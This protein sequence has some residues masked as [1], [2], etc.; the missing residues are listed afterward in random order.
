[1]PGSVSFP[2]RTSYMDRLT[3]RQK[4]HSGWRNYQPALANSSG[5]VTGTISYYFSY[6]LYNRKG[7]LQCLSCIDKQA[8]DRD[9]RDASPLSIWAC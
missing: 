5:C 7:A 6:I 9:R 4:H 1:M 2:C 3:T 8:L